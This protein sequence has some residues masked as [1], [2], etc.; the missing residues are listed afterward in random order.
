MN[1]NRERLYLSAIFLFCLSIRIALLD[2]KNLWFDEVF[3]WNITLTS[4]YEIVVRTT[5]DIHPPLYYFILKIW[6]FLFGDSIFTMRLL[7]AICTSLAVFFIFGISKRFLKASLTYIPVILYCISPLNLY[8][9]QEA[10]M[11]GMNLLFNIAAVYYFIRILEEEKPLKELFKKPYF[12]LF[13]LFQSAALYTHY[14]SFFILAAEIIS[15]IYHFKGA[16][17]LYKPFLTAFSF[18]LAIYLVWI[19]PLMIHLKRGQGW[20]QKQNFAEV[21]NE[22]LNFIKDLSL[23]LYYHYTNLNFIKIITYFL[24]GLALILLI[25]SFIK[26]KEK[27]K[28]N[29]P[30][31]IGFAFII[32]VIL[33]IIISFNQ[34]I[35]FY[36]YLVIL[37]PYLCIILVYLLSKI[38][39]KFIYITLIL[40]FSCINLFGISLHYKFDFK[41][42][43]Y[44]QIIKDINSNYKDG[45][46]IYVFP[47]YCGWII[48]YTRKQENLK[49]PKFVNHQYGWDV[50]QDSLKT[51]NPSSF[52]L[53]MD[54]CDVDTTEFHNYVSWIKGNYT[55]T[56]EENISNGSG[57]S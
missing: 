15:L 57:K 17:R 28:V 52:W 53:V 8:Y 43:D 56:S 36:R 4:F 48:D 6:I 46:K 1:K 11:S 13:I 22:V 26:P 18:V 44:R 23:G 12:I 38:K 54:Y 9:S 19:P 30:V 3:S 7:S 32:P 10:R 29:F 40:V 51:Q 16:I 49:I 20:R 21:S 5:N 42:D 37:V 24:L 47:H 27:W 35:E 33:A 55:E 14:F 25:L 2:Q 45:E 39:I 50:L 31:I 34:H 41:N